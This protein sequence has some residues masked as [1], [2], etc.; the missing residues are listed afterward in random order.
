MSGLRNASIF[1]R[2]FGISVERWGERRG[3]VRLLLA[4]A[5][6]FDGAT[7]HFLPVDAP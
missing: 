3:V 4:H 7:G 2:I 1:V 6:R 5:R